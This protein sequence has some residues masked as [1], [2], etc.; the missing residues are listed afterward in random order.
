MPTL[1]GPQGRVYSR[2][3]LMFKPIVNFH[4]SLCTNL[5]S[6]F[7]GRVYYV[8]NQP[9]FYKRASIRGEHFHVAECRYYK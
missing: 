5:K 9:I 3:M 8:R 6:I 1:A 2:F 7:W 4:I